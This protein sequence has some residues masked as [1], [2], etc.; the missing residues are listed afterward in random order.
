[1]VTN[2][3]IEADVNWFSHET[4]LCL[5]VLP[6]GNLS[7]R[8]SVDVLEKVKRERKKKTHL[9]P[10]WHD[11]K[12]FALFGIASLNPTN[13]EDIRSQIGYAVWMGQMAY[14]LSPVNQSS[15]SQS[16][17]SVKSCTWQ[18]ADRAFLRVYHAAL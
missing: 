6:H 10:E 14:S 13:A 1:M 5:C 15:T 17:P 4:N 3:L 12:A 8:L 2:I 11:R 9:A 7:L 18:R 16:W